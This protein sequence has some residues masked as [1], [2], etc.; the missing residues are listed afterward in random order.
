MKIIVFFL[1]ILL[2]AAYI[3]SKITQVK[4]PFVVYYTTWAFGLILANF[5]IGLFLYIFR[6]S[7]QSSGGQ[8]GFKGNIGIRGEEGESEFCNFCLTKDELDKLNKY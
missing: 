4:N 1:I 7:I 3:G 5:I 6:H 2:V 8:P